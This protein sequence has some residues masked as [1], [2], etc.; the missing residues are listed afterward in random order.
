MMKLFKKNPN[1][2][3]TELRRI[4]ATNEADEKWRSGLADK[5]GQLEDEFERAKKSLENSPSDAAVK[6]LI[7]S[8]R[9]RMDAQNYRTADEIAG[10]QLFRAAIERTREPLLK[11]LAA[12][13]ASL[14]EKISEV[15]EHQ[16]KSSETLGV[17][18]RGGDAIQSLESQ[19]AEARSLAG[20]VR[21]TASSSEP[22]SSSLPKIKE[23]VEFV[24][25]IT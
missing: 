4:V 13:E 5:A 23:A 20:F 1:S 6:R 25:S 12:I 17:E 11:A 18:L 8:G 10:Q 3:V 24:F 21:E 22:V 14:G 19:I 9:A 2:A 7:E 15:Q 16:R